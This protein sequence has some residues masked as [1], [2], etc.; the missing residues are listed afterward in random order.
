VRVPTV[1]RPS[2]AGVAFLKIDVDNAQDV[3][4]HNM[5][6]AMPTFMLFKNGEMVHKMVG[7]SPQGLADAVAKFQ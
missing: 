3:A 5:I 7:A 1:S 4:A 6:E 2:R